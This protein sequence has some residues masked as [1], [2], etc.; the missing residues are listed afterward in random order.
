MTRD[1]NEAEAEVNSLKPKPDCRSI[2]D[3]MA[4]NAASYVLMVPPEHRDDPTASAPK[5]FAMRAL[6]RAYRSSRAI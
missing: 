5:A 1:M 2:A 3:A 4:G 6:H